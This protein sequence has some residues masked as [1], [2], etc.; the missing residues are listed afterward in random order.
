MT[1]ATINWV[2]NSVGQTPFSWTGSLANGASTTVTLGNYN[3][4]TAG[5]HSVSA[6]VSNPNSQTDQNS[7]N[8]TVSETGLFTAMGGT[9]TIGAT[10]NYTTFAAAVSALQSNGICA[11]VTF[12]VQNGTY[13]ENITIPQI[14][15]ASSTNRITFQSL[16]N[17]STLVTLTSAAT[18]PVYMNGADYITFRKMTIGTTAATYVFYYLNTCEGNRIENCRLNGF[19]TT[20]T[21]TAYSIIFNSTTA[22]NDANNEFRNN[23]FND[24]SFAFYW[25]GFT[26]SPYEGGLI[27]ENNRF[28]NQAFKVLYISY[29]SAPVI[30]GNY[31]DNTMN[32]NTTSWGIHL[33]YCYNNSLITRNE[34]QTKVYGMNL[35]YLYGTSSLRSTVSNNIVNVVHPTGTTL[36]GIYSNYGDYCDFYHNTVS[37]TSPSTS[38]NSFALY[39][40][41]GTYK[42]ISNNIFHDGSSA[43]ANNFAVYIFTS[44][45]VTFDYNDYWVTPG[46]TNIAYHSSWGSFPV[47][48]WTTFRNVSYG[49][50]NSVNVNPSFISTTNRRHYN[51]LLNVG[52]NLLSTVPVDVDNRTRTTP[53]T[54][55]ANEYKPVAIDAGVVAI[56]NNPP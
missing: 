47:T 41:Y 53:M 56:L 3:F 32:A 23:V 39:L 48:S 14:S 16:N 36:Y 17:D 2:V 30:R 54:I 45:G 50:A 26:T 4:S 9:Y 42:T 7:A 11:P 21:T 1:S 40:N 31:M 24:G 25:T 28:I 55:G 13:N 43:S 12:N 15:G 19:V 38:F 18:Y 5:P 20:S 35:N 27:I 44:T 8:N 22:N 52:Q 10:G 37:T 6:T 46:S 49:G 29:C 33:E 51:N 34:I